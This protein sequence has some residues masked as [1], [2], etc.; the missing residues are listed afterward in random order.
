MCFSFENEDH[1]GSISENGEKFHE[2]EIIMT[3]KESP[4]KKRQKRFTVSQFSPSLQELCRL[5]SEPTFHLGP[6]P[7]EKDDYITKFGLSEKD[8]P[9]LLEIA[10]WVD[11]DAKALGE[12]F[13]AP[14]Y[15]WNALMQFD[16]ALVVPLVLELINHLDWDQTGGFGDE[17][18]FM[19]TDAGSRA[20]EAI[21]LLI[22]AVKDDRRH[23][24]TRIMLLDAVHNAIAETKGDWSALHT[25]LVGQ[26]KEFRIG[27]RQWYGA[28]VPELSWPEVPT[29]ELSELLSRICLEG[30]ADL[31][32]VAS[33]EGLI[34]L[35]RLD[36]EQDSKYR[37]LHDE[38]KTIH[39]IFDEFRNCERTF[40]KHAVLQ[41]RE[42]REQIIPSLVEAIREKTAY[43]R[44]GVNNHDG[45]AQ[46]AVHLLAEFQAKEALPAIYDSLSIPVDNIYDHL[47]GEGFYE[48]MPGIMHRL[49]GDGPTIYDE[50]LRDPQMP[51]SLQCCLSRSLKYLVA[52]NIVSEETYADW[53][54]DYLE[55]AIRAE[56]PELVTDLVCDIVYTG[57]PDYLPLVRTAFDKNLVDEDRLPWEEAEDDLKSRN[58]SITQMLPDPADDYSDTIAEL[59]SWAWFQDDDYLWKP[60]SKPQQEQ[61]IEIDVSQGVP[62]GILHFSSINPFPG[63]PPQVDSPKPIRNEDPKVGR[64]DPCPCGSGK[65]FK[66]CCLKN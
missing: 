51:A 29:P 42:H 2:N 50:K 6:W 4:Y 62:G 24:R 28:I 37:P 12:F 61:P 57:N 9:A 55:I 21:P 54:C 43:A 35:T 3:E 33:C 63:N 38:F 1:N 48:S 7:V 52:K 59:S 36:F 39:R 18:Q 8:I 19:L 27:C 10:S 66:K 44:F 11:G 15:A 22:D 40:P 17:I 26:L 45:T 41:A 49:I 56:K 25:F 5:P 32:M 60:Q 16:P 23:D 46:F 14:V 58:L 30:Y 53:L 31:L 34:Q 65:K 13:S 47:Y 64:N 20:P